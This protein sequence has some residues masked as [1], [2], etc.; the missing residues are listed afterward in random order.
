MAKRF[1]VHGSGGRDDL[2]Y[3]VLVCCKAEVESAYR[4]GSPLV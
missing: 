2:V 1:Q 3:R 4:Y